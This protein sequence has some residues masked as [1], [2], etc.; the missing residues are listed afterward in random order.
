M[1]SKLSSAK[2]VLS[3]K[4]TTP[5][6]NWSCPSNFQEICPKGKTKIAKE[7]GMSSWG[8]LKQGL[9]ADGFLCFQSLASLRWTSPPAEFRTSRPFSENATICGDN[10]SCHWKRPELDETWQCSIDFIGLMLSG[11]HPPS[12]ITIPSTYNLNIFEP[13]SEA[14]SKVLPFLRALLSNILLGPNSKLHN[15]LEGKPVFKF[16]GSI[17]ISVWDPDIHL[18]PQTMYQSTSTM[19]V[20]RWGKLIVCPSR[21]QLH[22]TRVSACGIVVGSSER[23]H[24]QVYDN[25]GNTNWCSTKR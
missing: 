5:F 24:Q 10:L 17:F 1:Q 15:R 12:S 22:R 19:Y 23:R 25:Q 14:A 8:C 13:S 18:P 4:L 11:H 20:L 21:F 7:K 3:T 16:M 6:R 2:K 9:K